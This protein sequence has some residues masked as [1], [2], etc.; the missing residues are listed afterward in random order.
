MARPPSEP[1]KPVGLTMDD[2]MSTSNRSRTGPSGA[3]TPSSGGDDLPR[4]LGGRM[5][6][7]GAIHNRRVPPEEAETG[8]QRFGPKTAERARALPLPEA[9]QA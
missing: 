2:L 9:P 1:P 6:M 7:D 4:A 8:D 5:R 3:A